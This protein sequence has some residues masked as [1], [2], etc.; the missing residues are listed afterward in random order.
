M[1]DEGRTAAGEE[2]R[3]GLGSVNSAFFSS[4]SFES[5]FELSDFNRCSTNFS[6]FF[7]TA[8]AW[9]KILFDL[10]SLG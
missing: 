4:E 8:S 6:V 5:A 10:V 3:T 7:I 9:S 1:E 2:A